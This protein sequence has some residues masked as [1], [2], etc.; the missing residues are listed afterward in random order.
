MVSILGFIFQRVF[1][2]VV[3]GCYLGVWKYKVESGGGDMQGKV[4]EGNVVV[5]SYEE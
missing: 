4:L 5:V 1:L 3:C 2:Y